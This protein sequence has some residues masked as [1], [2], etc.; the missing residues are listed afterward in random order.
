M[1]LSD[2]EDLT[3][4]AI[5][6]ISAD[7][8]IVGGGDNDQPGAH[9]MFTLDAGQTWDD[10]VN[11]PS[12]N[13]DEVDHI[14]CTPSGTCWATGAGAP[15]I[16]TATTAQMPVS[17]LLAETAQDNGMALSHDG[18]RTW[19]GVANPR[20]WRKYET[21]QETVACATA[22]CLVA[23]GNAIFAT[24]ANTPEFARR[25]TPRGANGIDE[26]TCAPAGLCLATYHIGPSS[27]RKEGLSMSVNLGL[28]WTDLAAAPPGEL[29][30]SCTDAQ[31][32]ATANE[33]LWTTSDAGSQWSASPI[34]D[35]DNFDDVSCPQLGHCVV[36]GYAGVETTVWFQGGGP[37]PPRQAQPSPPWVRRELPP[38]TRYFSAATCWTAEECVATAG[39]PSATMF[40][41]TDG[42]RSWQPAVTQPPNAASGITAVSCSAGGAC[43]A[44][45]GGGG[46]QGELAASSDAGEQWQSVDLPG[47]W[48]S[49]GVTPMSV[50]CSGPRCV[51][52]GDNQASATQP[53]A[54]LVGT[55]DDGQ[56]WTNLATPPDATQAIAISCSPEESCLF[57]YGAGQLTVDA[58]A[59]SDDGGEHW[60]LRPPSVDDWGLVT[61]ASCPSSSTCYT[62]GNFILKTDDSGRTWTEVPAPPVDRT[63]LAYLTVNE[64]T[65]PGTNSCW[66]LG[67]EGDR[68][69]A[70]STLR[71]R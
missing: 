22:T 20:S 9:L 30:I 64:V 38:Y 59:F 2:Q 19:T 60:V 37:L 53:V 12:T 57:V 16:S 65:C 1:T 56:T 45:V 58:L 36:L 62:T 68:A 50:S 55:T 11:I 63:G 43:L 5:A 35:A 41:T 34:P 3:A 6:C 66:L 47:A 44:I 46:G 51:V 17:K 25:A 69:L 28:S 18:G 13:E 7:H 48:K 4:S 10:V 32:C 29:G 21:G 26:I 14:S 42:G 54:L 15:P 31:H 23:T 39:N 49:A 61:S 8:C 67:S 33:E 40:R 70:W 27:S 71:A 24:P 52:A